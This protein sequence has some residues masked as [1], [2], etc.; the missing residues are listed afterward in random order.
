MGEKLT[1]KQLANALSW[2]IPPPFKFLEGA[3][4]KPEEVAEWLWVVIQGDFA[5]EHTTG[6]IVTGT[7]ISMIPGVDQIFDIR[8]IIAN[9]KKIK[10]DDSNPWAWLGLVLTLIGL[11]PVLGSL[12]KGCLKVLFLIVRK[13]I[14]KLTAGSAKFGGN[15][16]KF[17]EP[18]VEKGITELNKFL[19]RP[20]VKRALKA[21]DVSDVYKYLANEIRKVKGM[22]KTKPLMDVLDTQIVYLKGFVAHINRYGTAAMKTQAGELVQTVMEIRNKANKKLA[23]FLAP[24][25]Y[26]LEKCALRLEIESDTIYKVG[27]NKTNITKQLGKPADASE[28]LAS[29]KK[30]KPAWVDKTDEI[31]HR[32]EDKFTF[33]AGYPNLEPVVKAGEYHPLKNAHIT[34]AKGAAKPTAISEGEV[35]YRVLDP[36]SADNSIC[37]MRK[38][39]F[40]K[41]KSKDDWRRKFA[42]WA[43][44]NSNGEYV[45]YTVP[46]GG[47]HVWE[48][49][50][51]TQKIMKT[52][53]TL[54]GGAIQIVLDPKDLQKAYLSK[55]KPTN[56]GYGSGLA[57]APTP[58]L[59]G[60]P[61]LM[62]KFIESAK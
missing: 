41:L 61:V 40:D 24:V 45:T 8:D 55:H 54:E 17:V 32:A 28:E 51:A 20:E 53:F 18:H 27:I 1:A 60:V 31:P 56:W 4:R 36:S 14:F 52:D 26:F 49:A 46:K 39:E 5:A 43:N 15:L 10:S 7:V 44:W 23:E 29:I 13:Y 11:F 47:I 58:N 57:D 21:L 12:A 16:Y 30:K 37:W 59:V 48:G 35:L 42:V 33:V 22:V 34:F 19:A 2:F 6:Q 62:N 3:I 38:S 25:T 50:A 9:C